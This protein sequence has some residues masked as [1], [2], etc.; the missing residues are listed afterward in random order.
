MLT[1]PGCPARLRLHLSS[2]ECRPVAC[3]A[4]TC[5]SCRLRLRTAIVRCPRARLVATASSS[6][7]EGTVCVLTP[8]VFPC[9]PQLLLTNPQGALFIMRELRANAS[10]V[11]VCGG[12]GVWACRPHQARAQALAWLLQLSCL[13]H[14]AELLGAFS[15]AYVCAGC[16]PTGGGVLHL[17]GVP[18]HTSH[19]WQELPRARYDTS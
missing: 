4:A 8:A 7:S 17:P 1:G 6:T 10:C 15:T 16:V 12:P 2:D 19:D 3:C 18:A 14:L 11:I 13:G 5:V 9:E